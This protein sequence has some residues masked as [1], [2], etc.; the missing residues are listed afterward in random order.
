MLEV[1]TAAKDFLGNV[2]WD[3]QF[4]ARP[5]KRAI[6][7]QLENPLA[8]DILAGKIAAGDTVSADVEDG[9]IVFRKAA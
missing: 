7:H 4:G 6:Q 2:G 1:T 3:P 5:L 8:Q 9:E